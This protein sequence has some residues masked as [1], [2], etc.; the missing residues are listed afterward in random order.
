MMYSLKR[1]GPEDREEIKKVFVSVFTKEPW[2]DDWSDPEQL[3]LYIQ[4]LTGQGYSMTYGLFD[5]E[6]EL[7]G[8]SLGYI[9]HW[10]SGTEYIINEL[11]IR[12]DRQGAGAGT[13]FIRE[14]EKAIRELGLKQIF[15][16]TDSNV[17]ACEF[18]RKN[19]FTECTSNVA[20]AKSIE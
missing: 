16:L 18:Y 5:D 9:K 12:T 3:D 2:C 4:D 20:F 17:P 1:L 19:G 13:F 14:I 15:L 11:C 10:Y 7:I 6:D 8:I